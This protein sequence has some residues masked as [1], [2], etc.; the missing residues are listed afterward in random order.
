M[1]QAEKLRNIIK[2][3]SI[4]KEH[5]ARVITVTSGKGGVGKTSV[6]VNLALQ[7]SKLGNRVLILDADFGLA[8]IEVMFGIRPKYTL[9]DVIFHGKSLS[10]VITE[11]PENI[12][13]LSGGSGIRGLSNMDRGQVVSFVKNLY[14]L[15]QMAD[16]IIIDTGAGISD[17]V[18]E[19]VVASSEVLIVATPEPASIT[20]A[21]AL[22]KTLKRKGG[23]SPENTTIRMIGNRVQKREEGV[24][25]FEKLSIVV[26]KFLDI[27]IA[28]LGLVPYDD[29][30]QRAIMKQSP[31]SLEFPTAS[32]SRS[33]AD[34]AMLLS[35]EDGAGKVIKPKGIRAL[36][37]NV[38]RMR[39][40]K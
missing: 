17:V 23:F 32:S 26:K 39:F 12:G 22:L 40:Q 19:F 30:C 7:L 31:V 15:D 11:G 24:E 2:S 38:I 33:F 36:F 3:N 35:Y 5:L 10:E 16:I 9:A 34:I 20:D 29:K 25:L 21:Y 14:E 28:L 1:D 4:P 37:S 8:N 6:S 13:F 27:D 18:M